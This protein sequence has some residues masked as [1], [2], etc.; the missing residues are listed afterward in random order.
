M[1]DIK[2][3]FLQPDTLWETHFE[4]L[5]TVETAYRNY[6]TLKEAFG[7]ASEIANRAHA[8]WRATEALRAAI[9]EQINNQPGTAADVPPNI[10]TNIDCGTF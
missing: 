3:E 5:E 9:L 8:V 1:T 10:P 4:L 7:A 2:A 6:A